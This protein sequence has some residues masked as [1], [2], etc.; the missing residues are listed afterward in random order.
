LSV[1][2]KW[3][4]EEARST[5]RKGE[6]TIFP[7]FV[8]AVMT[9]RRATCVAPPAIMPIQNPAPPRWNAKPRTS[10]TGMPIR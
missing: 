9:D 8:I 1:S 4:G 3:Y 6:P 10:A 7:Q 5:K 2:V